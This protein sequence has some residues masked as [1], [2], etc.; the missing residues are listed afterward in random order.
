M[1]TLVIGR[2]ALQDTLLPLIGE[3]GYVDLNG[4]II[5][6]DDYDNETDYINA[7]PGMAEYLTQMDNAPDSEWEE[8]PKECFHV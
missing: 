2:E 3:G 8:V 6:P 5:N 7:I 1:T 4:N